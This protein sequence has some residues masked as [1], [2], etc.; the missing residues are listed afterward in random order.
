MGF[1][2]FLRT[3]G[4]AC[5]AIAALCPALTAQA[6]H[7]EL[8]VSTQWLADHLNDPKVVVLQVGEDR[9]AYDKRH[10]PG[11][12]FLSDPQYV[13]GHEGLM[14]ELPPVEQLKKAFED[15][16]VS[17][18]T[19]VVIYTTEWYPTAGRAFFTLDYLGHKNT[20]LLNGSFAQWE[21]EHRPVS[22]DTPQIAKGT[23]SPRVKEAA[24]AL[25]ANAK[26][27]TQPDSNT[28]LL[29]ARPAKRYTS[30][31]LPGAENIFWEETVESAK[32]PVF[33]P[34]DQ[35]KKL[36]ASRGVESGHK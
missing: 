3:V 35:L 17:D 13:I 5:V 4:L 2:R 18:D 11:A 1:D 19:K 28:T 7:P 31:H 16:G 27:A 32:K 20:A 6:A 33:L 26:A 36:F 25:L 22:R 8:L 9:G 10:I 34:P 30:G 23:I 29:D 12:R 21:S 15:V 24:R 14:F